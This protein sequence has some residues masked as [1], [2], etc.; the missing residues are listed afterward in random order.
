[1]P[2]VNDMGTRSSYQPTS[3][4]QP[5][6][7]GRGSKT[8]DTKR[9]VEFTLGTEIFAINLFHTREVDHPGQDHSTSPGAFLC[10]R[11]HGSQGEYHR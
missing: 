9:F 11:C 6:I 8:G 2:P 10:E 4:V 5:R 1:M 7:T 3:V